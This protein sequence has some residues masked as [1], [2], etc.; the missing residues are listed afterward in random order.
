MRRSLL[1]GQPL[2]LA[3][4][5]VSLVAG[6]LLVWIVI[7]LWVEFAP[8]TVL[9]PDYTRNLAKQEMAHQ[10][11]KYDTIIFGDSKA[12]AGIDPADLNFPS[13]NLAES[14]FN[15]AIDYYRAKDLLKCE[16]WPNFVV[17]SYSP[18]ALRHMTP[19][20][21]NSLA[22]A[23]MLPLDDIAKIFDSIQA[24][25]EESILAPV[26]FEATPPFSTLPPALRILLYKSKMPLFYAPSILSSLE[27]GVLPRWRYNWHVYSLTLQRRGQ[28]FY[29]PMPGNDK[30][31]PDGSAFHEPTSLVMD[32]Y[33]NRLIKLF[34]TRHIQV[35][36]VPIPINQVTLDSIT[37]EAAKVYGIWLSGVTAKFPGAYAM[38]PALAPWPVAMFGDFYGHPSAKGAHAVSTLIGRCISLLRAH[39]KAAGAVACPISHDAI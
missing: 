19:T 8:A 33:F 29:A 5:F 22:I 11:G 28:E 38:E 20:E 12:R 18:W 3:G 32:E 25:H 9:P 27:S 37:P 10:C 39:D 13:L 2:S 14:G 26:D 4:F 31:F 23:R 34:T 35:L 16:R 15:P 24:E 30:I 36:I 21:T 7:G 6:M 1:S 17:L